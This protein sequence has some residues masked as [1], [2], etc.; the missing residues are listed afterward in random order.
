MNNRKLEEIISLALNNLKLEVRF[1]DSVGDPRFEVLSPE[2]NISFV[3]TDEARARQIVLETARGFLL[4]NLSQAKAL[5]I[6][7]RSSR[8]PEIG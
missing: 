4:E 7:G 2:L 8:T 5:A 1:N 3:D 6:R